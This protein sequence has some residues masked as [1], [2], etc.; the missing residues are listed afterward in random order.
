MNYNISWFP[1]WKESILLTRSLSSILT[2]PGMV[3]FLNKYIWW[4][5]KT[6]NLGELSW[7]SRIPEINLESRRTTSAESK[8]YASLQLHSLR[9]TNMCWG[10]TWCQELEF[11]LFSFWSSKKFKPIL[12]KQKKLFGYFSKSRVPSFH[13]PWQL[14]QISAGT[15]ALKKGFRS[16]KQKKKKRKSIFKENYL[17]FSDV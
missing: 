13:C 6:L 1:H 12:I 16:S 15:Q 9:L 4:G 10:P 5:K 3:G 7:F 17:Y 11:F 2:Q 8:P 14:E